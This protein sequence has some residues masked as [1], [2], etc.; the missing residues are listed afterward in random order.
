MPTDLTLFQNP[1]EMTNIGWDKDGMEYRFIF[2]ERGH[3]HLRI[4]GINQNGC[5]RTLVEENSKTFINYTHKLYWRVINTTGELLWASERDGWNHVYL[6]DP[7]TGLK[8]QITKDEWVVCSVEKVDEVAQCIWFRGYGMVPG[9][10]PYYTQLA[11]VNFDG[12]GFRILTEGNGTHTWAWLPDQRHLTDIWSKVD[13]PPASVLQDRETGEKLL[14]LQENNLTSL[15]VSGWNPPEIFA[16]P[17]HDRKTVIY[18]IIV[19][20]SNFDPAKKYPVLED[21]YTGPQDFYTPKAFSNLTSYHDWADKGYIVVALDGMGTNW[22]SKAF[23]DVCYKQLRDA[24]FPDRIA[25][26]KAAAETRPW[27]D[28]SRMGVKGG[29]AGGQNAAAALLFHGDFYKVAAA[30][31]GCHDNRMD[32]IWWNEQWMGYPVDKS[33]EDSSNMVHTAQLQGNLMLIMGDLDDNM[34]PSSTL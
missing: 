25:W 23:H 9:Q 4:I 3:Q 28:L 13:Y 6:Y 12:T 16:A 18:G 10:D 17:G 11:R 29:S 34:D 7:E 8:N 19:R 31:S 32:K 30:D 20:P 33:Y 24:G 1:Y 26:M 21:I 27:M 2:N 22:R 15:V 14:T 5:V